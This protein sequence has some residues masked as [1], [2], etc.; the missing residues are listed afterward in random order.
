[1]KDRI[2]QIIVDG[3]TV[4]IFT[5]DAEK[6]IVTLTEAYER[7]SDGGEEFEFPLGYEMPLLTTYKFLGREYPCISLWF[8][9]EDVPDFFLERK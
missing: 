2:K 1:M 5:D 4:F 8:D 3:T 7:Y 6:D 9:N